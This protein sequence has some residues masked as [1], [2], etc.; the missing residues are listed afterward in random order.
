MIFFLS[1]SGGG[2]KARDLAVGESVWLTENG[3]RTEYLVVQQGNPNTGV[4]TDPLVAGT[5]ILRKDLDL[6][7]NI[8]QVAADYCTNGKY[9]ARFPAEVQSAFREVTLPRSWSVWTAVG[10][11][12][13]IT[14]VTSKIQMPD[15][16][17]LDPTVETSAT[18]YTTSRGSTLA[19]FKD[20]VDENR[21]ACLNGTPTGYWLFSG[22]QDSSAMPD[23]YRCFLYVSAAGVIT[24]NAAGT[25]G[26]WGFRPMMI[27]DP[28]TQFD[29]SNDFVGL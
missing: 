22:Y 25:T 28:D 18:W 26:E 8:R 2:K 21:V 17:E 20:D 10:Q 5:W 13:N 11:I 3:E 9:L 24:V 6:T 7:T 12:E 1:R 4:Y 14:E 29:A 19:Y 27:L 16:R 15:A 23:I